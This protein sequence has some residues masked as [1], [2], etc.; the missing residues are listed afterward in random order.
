MSITSLTVCNSNAITNMSSTF[1]FMISSDSPRKISLV[2]LTNKLCAAQ[3]IMK[4]AAYAVNSDHS[5]ASFSSWSSQTLPTSLLYD[6]G[7]F[8]D[9][10]SLGLFHVPNDKY[11]SFIYGFHFA[12]SALPNNCSWTIFNRGTNIHAGVSRI[13]VTSISSNNISDYSRWWWQEETV[14]DAVSGDNFHSYWGGVE[15]WD[16]FSGEDSYIYFYPLEAN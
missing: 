7:G 8:T 3:P 11:K 2:D 12:M 9:S 15:A 5:G 10:N 4:G 13:F 14:V 16:I 6:N 1:L